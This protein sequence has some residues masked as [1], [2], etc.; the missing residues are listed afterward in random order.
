MR[1]LAHPVPI[2]ALSTNLVA[3]GFVR[4][5]A[6]PSG[7]ITG[8]SVLGSELNGKRLEILMQVVPSARRITV[9]ADPSVAQS[10]ELKA[11]ENA[12]VRG[13]SNS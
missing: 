3:A 10:S 12:A 1:E 7:N 6:R 4:S 5:L 9:L 11:L 8:V 13:A 2:V